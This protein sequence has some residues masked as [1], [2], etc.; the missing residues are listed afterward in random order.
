MDEKTSRFLKW[1]TDNGARF[2][3]L[4]FPSTDT[5]SGM[6]GTVAVEAV[7]TD[8][9]ML[10]IPSQLMMSEVNALSDHVIGTCLAR[11]SDLISGDS[12]LAIYIMKEYLLGENSFYWPYLAI[13][14]PPGTLAEWSHG[15]LEELQD[16]LILLRTRERKLRMAVGFLAD[17]CD[18]D[19]NCVD[20]EAL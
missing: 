1:L 15:Q 13:L 8:E 11:N 19:E 10:E 14:P 20:V 2:P 12:L 17:A 6:R 4:L 3:K 16:D 7:E 9:V 18:G 5:I